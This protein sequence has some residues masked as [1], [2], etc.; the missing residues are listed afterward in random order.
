MVVEYIQQRKT[1]VP[2]SITLKPGSLFHS[3]EITTICSCILRNIFSRGK[4]ID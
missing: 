4:I 1:R 3:P 2:F